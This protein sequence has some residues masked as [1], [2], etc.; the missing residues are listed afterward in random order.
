M[1]EQQIKRIKRSII[2]LSISWG[3]ICWGCILIDYNFWHLGC[4]PL[5]NTAH[6]FIPPHITGL[7]R[8][9]TVSSIPAILPLALVAELK[10]ISSEFWVKVFSLCCFIPQV[11]CY[12][13]I[14]NV[15]G[16]IFAWIAQKCFMQTDNEPNDN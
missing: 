11:L 2:E 12:W 6:S 3:I 7:F 14:G 15:I 9:F 5:Y 1:N 8:L 4:S 16:R 13:Y 10:I